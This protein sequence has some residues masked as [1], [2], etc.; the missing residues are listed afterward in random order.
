MS[1]LERARRQAAVEE[2]WAQA[3]ARGVLW[4]VPAGVVIGASLAFGIALGGW[5]LVVG[6]AVAGVVAL[7]AVAIMA[8]L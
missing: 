3:R 7:G 8:G 5:V 4:G 6:L 1:E 2:M